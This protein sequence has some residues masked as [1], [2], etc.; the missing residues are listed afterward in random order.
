MFVAYDNV[1]KA[2]KGLNL[3]EAIYMHVLA[4]YSHMH[5]EN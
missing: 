5:F 1:T 4:C 3:K 2:G